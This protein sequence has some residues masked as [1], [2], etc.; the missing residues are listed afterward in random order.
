MV[1]SMVRKQSPIGCKSQ[2]KIENAAQAMMV[3][4]KQAVA[5][6]PRSCRPCAHITITL[7]GH[8]FSYRTDLGSAEDGRPHEAHAIGQP[9]HADS[10]LATRRLKMA[11]GHEGCNEAG[12]Q[13]LR[14]TYC[15][16]GRH[17]AEDGNCTSH[18]ALLLCRICTVQTHQHWNCALSEPSMQ[19]FRRCHQDTLRPRE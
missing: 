10:R 7:V 12:H 6:Q 18:S 2:L 9:K 1:R 4:F 16:A 19:E 3:C 5:A 8:L 13:L 15:S 17:A 14:G 11:A